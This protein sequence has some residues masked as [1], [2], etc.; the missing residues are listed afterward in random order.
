MVPQY[1]LRTPFRKIWI[2]AIPASLLC[3]GLLNACAD[4]SYIFLGTAICAFFLSIW[5]TQYSITAGELP[6]KW[7]EYPL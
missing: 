2:A 7:Y 4:N 5:A 1:S 3:T 6:F